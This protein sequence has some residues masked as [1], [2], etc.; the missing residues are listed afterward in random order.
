MRDLR[1]GARMIGE[2]IGLIV[3]GLI[4]GAV[5]RLLLPGKQKIGL[6]RTLL[7]GVVAAVIAGLVVSLIGTGEIFELD[8]LGVVIAALI[9]VGLLAVAERGG[10]LESGERRGLERRS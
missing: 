5:A 6:L 1:Y 4:I 9:A 3:C 7:L 8:F 10:M 2:L